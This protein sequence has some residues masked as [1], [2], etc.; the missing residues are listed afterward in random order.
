MEAVVFFD[1]ELAKKAGYQRKRAGHLFSMMRFLSAQ[2]GAYLKDDLWR[3]N[4]KHANEMADRLKRSLGKLGCASFEYPVQAN[5]VF[6]RLPL[7]IIEELL[8]EGFMFY[9]WEPEGT[10]IRMIT[11]FDTNPED[12]DLFIRT[13]RKLAA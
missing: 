12:V 11:A 4:A 13:V 10:L 6:V 5:E 8:A 9:R 3:Q 1:L 7:P 2:F